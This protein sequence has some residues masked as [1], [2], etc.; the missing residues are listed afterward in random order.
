VIIHLSWEDKF[1]DTTS[2]LETILWAFA[3]DIRPIEVVN[4][5]EPLSP[6]SMPIKVEVSQPL[7]L[8]EQNKVTLRN[9]AH[10][11]VN[12]PFA[13]PTILPFR[14]WDVFDFNAPFFLCKS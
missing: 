11:V 12:Q 9:Q 14:A 1:L 8:T 5:A 10:L 7:N 2:L 13:L 4:F 3:Q 6:D